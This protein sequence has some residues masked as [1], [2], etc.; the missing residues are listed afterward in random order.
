MTKQER[1]DRRFFYQRAA[2]ILAADILSMTVAYFAALWIR[3]DFHASTIPKEHITGV[4]RFLPV[5]LVLTILIYHLLH[6]YQSVWSFASVTEA[7]RILK[8]Y[9]AIAPILILFNKFPRQRIPWSVLCMGYMMSGVC[10]VGIRFSYRYLRYLTHETAWRRNNANTENVLLVGAGQAARE[11][12]KDIFLGGHADLNICAIVDDKPSKRGKYLEG[13]RIEGSR[14]DIPD[15]V[16]KYKIKRIIFAIPSARPED[17]R[18]ILNICK[19]TG[20]RQ[21]TVPGLYQ[22]LDG[23]VSITKLRDVD[24]IDLLGREEI[25]V[26]NEEIYDIIEGKTVLVTGG[27][28]SIG[29]EL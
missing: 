14:R 28:G 3:F 6:L 1:A 9:A 7:S 15:L 29:S 4:I 11:I 24:P 19:E 18:D 13:V 8:A 25:R 27:G 23:E 21:Q 12:L 2:M 22:L 10:C 26:N 17:R 5:A 16:R 20:C